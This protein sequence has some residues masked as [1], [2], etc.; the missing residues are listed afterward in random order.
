MNPLGMSSAR[1]S[2]SGP[3]LLIVLGQGLT[4]SGVT[5]WAL[6]LA[7]GCARRGRGVA[8]LVHATPPATSQRPASPPRTDWLFDATDL[9]PLDRIGDRL[10][11]ATAPRSDDPGRADPAPIEPFLARYRQA[12]D[13]LSQRWGGPVILSPNLHAHSYAL[14]AALAQAQPGKVRVV[15]WQHADIV[16]DRRVLAFYEPVLTHL[17]GVSARIVRSLAAELPSRQADLVPLPYGVPV[18][19]M[20]P[21]RPRARARPI[22]LIYT[23]R[24]EHHQKRILALVELSRA[25]RQMGIEHHVSVFG[26][27]PARTEL[28][29]AADD[30]DACLHLHAPVASRVLA[31]EL[32]ASDAFVLPSRYEGLSVAM[33]EAMSLG[34]VPI[35][36]RVDSGLDEAIETGCNGLIADVAPHADEV[37]TGRALA[38]LVRRLADSDRRAMSRAA[39]ETVRRRFSLRA[40]GDAVQRLVVA[41]AQA[42]P[43]SWPSHRPIWFDAPD[44][45]GATGSVPADGWR[46]LEAVLRRLAGRRVAIH[47]T[48]AHTQQLA[49]VLSASPATIVAFTDDDRGRHG[50]ELFGRPVVAPERAAD[51]GATD[52]VISSWMHESAIWARRATYLRQGLRVHRLYG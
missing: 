31:R 32:A 18:P 27:G 28:A 38:E 43:R 24:L 26:D 41:A 7:R 11:S 29:R 13:R 21:A 52:V 48:G 14:A 33:L 2:R 34:C 1:V 16:Y 5:S 40:H 17:V 35:V 6:R 42:G 39:W 49:G 36:A 30:A 37:E 4:L 51:T 20:V 19:R 3:P 10:R 9:G 47:G 23:G 44:A 15:G 8:L 12:V 50:A 45:D 25:L 46:R 22:R